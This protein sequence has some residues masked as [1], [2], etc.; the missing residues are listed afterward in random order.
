MDLT[1]LTYTASYMRNCQ[2]VKHRARIEDC[3]GFGDPLLPR[4]V[5]LRGIFARFYP[6]LPLPGH[7]DRVPTVFLTF[8]ASAG[9]GLAHTLRV[10][11]EGK[12]HTKSSIYCL[13]S[14]DETERQRRSSP[15]ES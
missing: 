5:C 11:I 13:L 15:R 7:Y 1:Y 8:V 9:R 4:K 6:L 2:T 3:T 12:H 10:G 14:L